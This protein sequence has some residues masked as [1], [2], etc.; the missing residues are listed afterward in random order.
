[1]KTNN[2]QL[3]FTAL[4]GMGEIGANCYLYQLNNTQNQQL[5]EIL[6]VD[7]GMGFSDARSASVD[8]YIPNIDYLI[9]NKE[10]IKGLAVTHGHEDHIGAIGLL[11]K[12]L[13]C[14]IY[15]T[16][17]TA[18]IIY[19]KLKEYNLHK[20]AQIYVVNPNTFKEIGAFNVMWA[21]V[22]HSI[23]DSNLLV[24]KTPVG[25]VVHSGD[26][27]LT[28]SPQAVVDNLQQLQ[29][30]NIKYLMCDSTNV[31]D[32]NFTL[33]E[34]SIKPDLETLIKNSQGVC[35]IT[36][37][38]SNLERI[39]NI[40]DIAKKYKK[41]VV[42]WGRSANLYVALGIKHKYLEEHVFID[43]NDTKKYQRNQLIYF[44]TGGQGE[45]R[46]VLFNLL[47]ENRFK[48]K[49]EQGDCVIF[50][51]RIIP[52]NE[53][54]VSRLYNSLSKQEIDFYTPNDYHIHVSGHPK[55]QDLIQMYNL[56]KP[57][58]VIPI[59]GEH[60][61]LLQHS[62]FAQSLGFKSI[63]A[64]NGDVISLLPNQPSIVD[65]I[66]TSRLMYEG[67]RLLPY[68]DEVFTRR[69]KIFFEGTCFVSLVMQNN[70]PVDIKITPIGLLTN[71]EIDIII[72]KITDKLAVYL[73][74][75]LSQNKFNSTQIAEEARIFVRKYFKEYL[76]KKPVVM[77]NLHQM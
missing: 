47:V 76:A 75:T 23:I 37:F 58:Y 3:N 77:V 33:S 73:K 74:A 18:D 17:W 11:W 1:M 34:E 8:T 68:N 64:E 66:D 16:K 62:L 67:Y 51:S 4:G 61:H 59:H 55:Q 14:P 26:F 30:H 41:K 32:D 43:P 12:E 42:I 57:Q 71:T 5:D 40:A 10:K 70:N 13:R 56:I 28:T 39:K 19:E 22:T 45:Y 63:T 54:K 9:A 24:I 35:W 25:N 6:I 38:S 48:E 60:M 20:T 7:M 29:Q 21:P 69:S 27:K 52:G 15:T 36:S 53:N 72:P 31:L 49:I 50:S 44:V 46:S 65:K 2:L